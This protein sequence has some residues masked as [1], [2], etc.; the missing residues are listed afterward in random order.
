LTDLL[1]INTHHAA[2]THIDAVAHIPVGD[3]VYPG[4][5]VNEAAAGGTIQH[6]S[7]SVLAAGLATRGVLLDLAPGRR[8]P[9]VTR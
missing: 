4:V 3:M 2:L 9:N 1:V 7:T 8:W 6:G 5:P